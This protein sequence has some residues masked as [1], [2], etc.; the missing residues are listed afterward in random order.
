MEEKKFAYSALMPVRSVEGL[1]EKYLIVVEEGRYIRFE[2]TFK[3]V[4]QEGYTKEVYKYIQEHNIPVDFSFDY[5]EYPPAF[6]ASDP[7]SVIFICF[8]YLGE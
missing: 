8:R 2:T 7:N 3:A 1:D 6:D 4:T 5:E